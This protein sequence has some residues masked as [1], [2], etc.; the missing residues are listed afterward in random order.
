MVR[1]FS[2]V[3]PGGTVLLLFRR[4]SQEREPSLAPLPLRPSSVRRFGVCA[5]AKN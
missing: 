4:F 2:L 1:V 3:F 5:G